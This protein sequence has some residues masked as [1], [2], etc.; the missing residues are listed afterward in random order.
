M[1]N[2][3]V[4]SNVLWLFSASGYDDNPVAKNTLLEKE[5]KAKKLRINP[6]MPTAW[7]TMNNQV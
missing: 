4:E 7:G 3:L 6:P 5:N 2:T 1:D